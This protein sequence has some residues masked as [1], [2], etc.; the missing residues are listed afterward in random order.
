MSVV[1]AAVSAIATR[2]DSWINAMTGLGTMRDKVTHAQIVPGTKLTD[3]ALE[4]LFNEDDLARRV[5]DNLPRDAT[6]RGF[7][8]VFESK[9]DDK[10]ADAAREM[11]LR[12]HDI[13]L[14][15]KNREAWIWARLYG[16]GAI[17][18]GADDGQEPDQPLNEQNI[19]TVRFLNVL[20]RPQ[21]TIRA[22]QED[23][24]APDFGEPT[25]YEVTQ[26]NRNG[27]M[28]TRTGVL[29]HASRLIVFPGALTAKTQ[30]A[31]VTGWDDSVLEAAH[32][33][34]KQQA[35]AWQSVVHLISDASQGVLKISNLVDLIATNGK[36]AL[37]ARIEMMDLARSVCRSILVD[38][39][40]ESFERVA[41]SFAGLPEMMDRLM[42][43]VASAAEQPITKLYGRSPAGLN[44][45]GE[46]DTRGWYDIVDDGQ[47]DVLKPRLERQLRILMLAK[48]SPTGG[49]VPERWSIEFVPLWQPTDKERADTLKVKA[50]T[51]VALVTANIEMEAEGALA[52]A[53]DIPTIDVEHRRD[54][55][56]TDKEEGKRPGETGPRPVD[57]PDPDD[58][59][60][61]DEEPDDDDEE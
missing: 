15:P 61:D 28:G 12:C 44:A 34:L 36:E 24:S 43:R 18:V 42:M 20:R 48:D 54:L 59:E 30:G 10:D 27:T 22:W 19:R 23:V 8:L 9:K 29:V 45:T 32:T 38:A 33:A 5:V 49:V 50:D 46:S 31:S 4:T 47:T 17:F 6:R 56:E 57:E 37:R 39:D 53:A 58:D 26:V 14:L 25:L 41:T 11:M 13:G 51:H 3:G 55:L 16:G 40:R 21:L 7:R 60:I 35:T 2:A 1:S 52:L